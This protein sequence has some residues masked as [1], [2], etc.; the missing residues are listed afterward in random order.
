MKIQPTNLPTTINKLELA[1]QLLVEAVTTYR[2]GERNVD[3]AKSILMAGAV[4]EIVSPLLKEH[5]IR[6]H[7][8]KLA[9]LAKEVD[10][11]SDVSKSMI[12]FRRPY[13]ALKHAGKSSTN[14]DGTFTWKTLPSSDLLIDLDLKDEA[15][16]LINS[17]IE[18][19]RTAVKA[20]L[21]NLETF[22]ELRNLLQDVWGSQVTIVDPQ[23]Y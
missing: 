8:I 21:A 7:Q 16:H 13:N 5:D 17:A 14:K 12:F 20:G 15:D 3:F 2:S 22:D 9:A 4:V 18:D 19:F 10:E 11:K 1:G 23:N 6:S